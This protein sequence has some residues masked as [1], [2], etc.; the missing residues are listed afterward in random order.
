MFRTYLEREIEENYQNPFCDDC[1]SEYWARNLEALP[2]REW[3]RLIEDPEFQDEA[4]IIREA[5]REEYEAFLNRYYLKD[6]QQVLLDIDEV[7]ARDSANAFECKHRLLRTQCVGGLTSYSG[8]RTPYF[9]ALASVVSDCPD[10]EEAAFAQD[11]MRKLGVSLGDDPPRRKWKKRRSNRNLPF[12]RTTNT[13][14]PSSFPWAE[15]T[16]TRSR[17]KCGR[18][19]QFIFRLE[20]PE[21]DEQFARPFHQ[22]VLVKSFPNMRE[23]MDYYTVFTGNREGSLRSIRRATKWC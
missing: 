15:A 16:A 13:T 10:T 5:Q 14:S 8:E 3:A 18:F 7:L 9:E 4:E 11:L 20:T 19:Q 12:N 22:V 23:G 17:Q 2:R 1:N 6:Y 21:S